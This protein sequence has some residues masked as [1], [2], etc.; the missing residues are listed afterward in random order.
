MIGQKTNFCA[1]HNII[2]NVFWVFHWLIL[3]INIVTHYIRFL[4][5]PPANIVM[6]DIQ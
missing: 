2:Y 4:G 3:H 5:F 1:E 6:Y